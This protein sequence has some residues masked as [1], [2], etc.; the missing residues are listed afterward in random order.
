MFKTTCPT[1]LTL[2]A[3]GLITTASAQTMPL[4]KDG[5][6]VITIHLPATSE[7][8]AFRDS[9]TAAIDAHLNTLPGGPAPDTIRT[10]LLKD[11]ENEIKRVGDEEI[12]A[13]EELRH[14]LQRITGA[15]VPVVTS[16]VDRLPDS[17]AILI[18][19]AFARTAGLGAEL[20]QL[21]PDGLIC[22][23]AGSH[24]VLSGRRARG[25][26]YAVY[27]LLESFGVR[28][29]MPGDFGEIIPETRDLSTAINRLENPSCSQRYW[30]CTY[31]QGD[32]YARWTL[33]NKG[34]FIRA[35]GDSAIAQ[36]HALS[37]PLSWGAQN[38]PLAIT[39]TVQKTRR[40]KL[41][42]GTFTNRIEN[43]EEKKLPDEF[44]ALSKGVPVRGVPNMSNPKTW[45]LYAEAY[46]DRFNRNPFD[47]YVS[48]S[49]EDGLTLDD[50]PESRRLDINEF[51]WTLGAMSA[52]DRMWFFH[53]RVIDRVAKKHPNAKFG[54]LVYSNNTMPP[55]IERVHPNM[56]LVFAPL[57]I[58]PLHA[59]RNDKCKTNREYRKWFES[60]MAQARAVK[61]ETYYYDYDPIGFSWNLA[62]ISPQWGII[63]KNY[64]W[65]HQ[66]GLGGHTTQ[67]H[68]DWAASGLN[69]W[70]M[71]RLYW[72]MEQDY[73]AVIEDYCRIRFGAAAPAMLEYFNILEKRMDEI[74]DLM[75]NEIWGNHLILT[76]TVRSR[77]RAAIQKATATA[78]TPRAK[79]H[80]ET[81]ADLQESTDI[82]C[83]GIEHARET[84]DFAA[85]ARLLEPVF[86][87][88]GKLNKLYPFFMNPKRVNKEEKTQYLTGGWYNKYLTFDAVIRGSAA[89]LILPRTMKIALDTDNIAWAK[90][91][92][93]PETPV[94]DLPDGD[95]T[96]IPDVTFG[97]E[98]EPAAFF[99][100]T[101][102]EV[103]ASFAN[104]KRIVLYCPSIIARAVQIWIN[105]VAVEFDHETFRD[106]TWRGPDYFWI[107]YNHQQQF[108]V[109]SAIKPGTRNTIAFRI[110]KSFD[111][112]GTYDRVFLLADP[113]TETAAK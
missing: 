96:L 50:R 25:T 36:G 32:G 1:I 110:F 71:I 31:G 54:V 44:Y 84:G 13:A 81:M 104:R 74:P 4:V 34:N 35:L 91:W 3:T 93:L 77:C 113:P 40:E 103:P 10:S 49:A 56:A 27:A 37:W 55:R 92:H 101:D 18:G 76:D 60:W 41:P 38:S 90:G 20:D 12:L 23:V 78:D 94:K 98:R 43:V 22:R 26:L 79:A 5:T 45:D 24:L 62:M 99:Y 95:S 86:E 16:A 83:D 68:D 28:W 85:A 17:P 105:G 52:T 89:R 7:L 2:L 14:Y 66:Q 100:R 33:R 75:S 64:P 47:R 51:D 102:V 19:A 11:L 107:D 63:G 15:T 53:N 48:I 21:Q 8:A 73:K 39:T 106:T 6:A 30:W 61:A 80:V 82:F 88:A 112:G 87:I 69:H 109:T 58:C 97:T 65:F 72:N 9:R 67:G 70:L 111:H 108:D 46:I 29:V 59:V 57:S 42:D